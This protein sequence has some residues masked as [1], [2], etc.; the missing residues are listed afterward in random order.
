[1]NKYEFQKLIDT[2]ESNWWYRSRRR[3]IHNYLSDRYP[4][5]PDRKILDVACAIGTNFFK[6]KEYGTITGIDVSEESLNICKKRG[7]DRVVKADVLNLPFENN[8]FDMIFS[9]DAL[10]HFEND[11][12]AIHELSRVLKN[13]GAIIV[14]VPANMLLWSNHDVSYHHFRRYTSHDL[15]VKFCNNGF[16]MEFITYWS[17]AI[18]FPVLMLRKIRTFFAKSDKQVKSDFFIKIPIWI[19]RT[20]NNIQVCESWLIKKGVKL[21]VGVSLFCVVKKGDS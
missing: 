13:D 11:T 21:P 12:A 20:L 8:S 3:I 4:K 16:K 15:K 1:M 14:T 9:F 2:E 18:F 17:M 6:F 19:E 5:T 7:I 10:E